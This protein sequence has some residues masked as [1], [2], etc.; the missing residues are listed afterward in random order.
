MDKAKV[1]I[2]YQCTLFQT[3][4]LRPRE[5]VL[6]AAWP[7][8]SSVSVAPTGTFGLAKSVSRFSLF[9]LPFLTGHFLFPLS[10]GVITALRRLGS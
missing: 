9:C 1:Q 4:K 3:G 7:R 6:Q 10:P 5:R 2:P 8:P